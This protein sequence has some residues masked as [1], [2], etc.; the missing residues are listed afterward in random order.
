MAL[1]HQWNVNHSLVPTVRLCMSWCINSMYKAF[2]AVKKEL[3]VIKHS[4][5]RDAQSAL[6]AVK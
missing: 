6:R 3:Y 4:A 2:V 5:F 1:K